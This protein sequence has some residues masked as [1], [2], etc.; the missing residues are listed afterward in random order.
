MKTID[1][2]SNLGFRWEEPHEY[3]ERHIFS[4]GNL[5]AK[6]V[7]KRADLAAKIL[8]LDKNEEIE[9]SENPTNINIICLSENY[10]Y[11]LAAVQKIET[12]VA[13][14]M[15]LNPNTSGKAL[16]QIIRF[17]LSEPSAPLI[18]YNELIEKSDSAEEMPEET[19]PGQ[20]RP[21]DHKNQEGIKN[22]FVD[23]FKALII[24]A[25]QTMYLHAPEERTEMVQQKPDDKDSVMRFHYEERNGKYILVY[26]YWSSDRNNDFNFVGY[27]AITKKT[28]KTN[29]IDLIKNFSNYYC[30]NIEECK[31]LMTQYMK[32][33]KNVKYI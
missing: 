17:E 21:K 23:L 26:A 1:N 11:S 9:V 10:Q 28:M 20:S 13:Q 25:G 29:N 7:L 2:L 24:T 12:I 22:F 6:I 33:C 4:N 32:R 27:F 19:K 3:A 5:S 30:Q 31:D 16:A 14:A 8:V 18:D 15:T